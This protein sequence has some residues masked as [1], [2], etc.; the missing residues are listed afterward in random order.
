[1]HKKHFTRLLSVLLAVTMLCGILA[2]PASAA[3][4]MSAPNPHPNSNLPHR[5]IVD[6]V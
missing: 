2:A 1:M 3:T 6:W 4:A 5:H